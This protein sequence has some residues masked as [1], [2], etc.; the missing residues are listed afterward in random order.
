MGKSTRRETEEPWNPKVKREFKESLEGLSAATLTGRRTALEKKVK[1]YQEEYMRWSAEHVNTFRKSMTTQF[2]TP[3]VKSIM[4]DYNPLTRRLRLFYIAVLIIVYVTIL[5]VVF[6]I[7]KKAETESV[8]VIALMVALIM[9]V[10]QVVI[11]EFAQAAKPNEAAQLL[12]LIAS[13]TLEDKA[14]KI[15]GEVPDAAQVQA[16][17]SA[18]RT[19]IDRDTK[20]WIVDSE[21]RIREINTKLVGLEIQKETVQEKINV[22]NEKIMIINEELLSR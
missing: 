18:H 10:L 2:P 1:E 21:E 8:A 6:P 5:L 14:R 16:W 15:N 11:T 19:I 20:N 13:M 3:D 17:R 12:R 4:K 22:V 7:G 9:P